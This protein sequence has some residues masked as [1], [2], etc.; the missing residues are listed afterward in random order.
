MGLHHEYYI[1]ARTLK[2][3]HSTRIPK[4]MVVV[5]GPLKARV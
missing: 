4:Y 2:E 1:V 3:T 5:Y